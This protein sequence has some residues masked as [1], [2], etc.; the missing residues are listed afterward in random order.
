MMSEKHPPSD[1]LRQTLEVYNAAKPENRAQAVR[2]E[3]ERQKKAKRRDSGE[4][5][6]LVKCA[7]VLRRRV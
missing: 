7:P 6:I 1:R 4:F 2:A 5:F 3:L